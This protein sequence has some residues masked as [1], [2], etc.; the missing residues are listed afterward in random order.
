M[1]F[2]Q[3][4]S[5]VVKNFRDESR[6]FLNPQLKAGVEIGMVLRCPLKLRSKR[7]ERVYSFVKKISFGNRKKNGAS[8]PF[9]ISRVERTL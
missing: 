6:G 4:N 1:K 8:L 5:L 9:N 3:R 7:Q 2:S